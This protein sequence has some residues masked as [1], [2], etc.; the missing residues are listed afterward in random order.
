MIMNQLT[1]AYGF[2]ENLNIIMKP[3][4]VVVKLQALSGILVIP[5]VNYHFLLEINRMKVGINEKKNIELDEYENYFLPIT[6]PK[7]K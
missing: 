3:V 6:K 1:V 2:L 7:L 4:F 5:S